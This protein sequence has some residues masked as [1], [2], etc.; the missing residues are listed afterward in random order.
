MKKLYVGCS[1]THATEEFRESVNVLKTKLRNE[2]TVL[3][4]IGLS[5]LTMDPRDVFTYD[6]S[7][8]EK[9]D[10]FVAECSYAS[11]GLGIELG[12]A[13]SLKKPI[14]AI[15]GEDAKVSHIIKGITSPHFS[16]HRYATNEDVVKLIKEKIETL[17]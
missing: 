8:V 13:Y 3:D 10:L 4:F 16:F 1:L 15:A 11:I 9:C 17:P 5:G 6:V 2:Y 14:L 12:V 7:N